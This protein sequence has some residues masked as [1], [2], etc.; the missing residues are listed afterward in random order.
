M[1]LEKRLVGLNET[2]RTVHTDYI[3][4]S[5]ELEFLRSKSEDQVKKLGI[6][7]ES[8]LLQNVNLKTVA[9]STNLTFVQFI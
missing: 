7:L 1:A 8:C 3:D 6:I 9:D 4:K 5:A 2:L